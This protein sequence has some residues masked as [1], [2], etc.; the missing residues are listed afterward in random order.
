M[1][2]SSAVKKGTLI[3]DFRLSLA[4]AAGTP[5]CTQGAGTLLLPQGAGTRLLPFDHWRNVFFS[6]PSKKESTGLKIGQCFLNVVRL[7]Q[8]QSDWVGFTHCYRLPV[9]EIMKPLVIARD[10]EAKSVKRIGS[11]LT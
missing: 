1:K 4:R 9:T 5:L 6:I 7:I 11:S 3:A 8:T 2:Q 10:P